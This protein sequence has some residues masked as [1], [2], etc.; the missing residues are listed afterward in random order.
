MKNIYL[1]CFSGISGNMFIGSFLDAGVPEEYLRQELQKLN[2]NN[3]Y[4]LTIDKVDKQGLHAV[5]FNVN[6]INK[7]H[8]HRC[9]DN[10]KDII[11]KSS[12]DPIVKKTALTV[13]TK[14]ASAE[15]K[16]HDADINKIH[17]HEVGAVDAIIDIVGTAICM[18]Y[19]D[20]KNIF[21]FNLH[22]GTGFVDCDHGK[23]PIPAPATAQLLQGFKIMTGTTAKELVTPTGAALIA[24][25]AQKQ[26]L[27]QTDFSFN[28]I[29]Y[30]AGTWDLDYP[31]VLR[32]YI[33]NVTETP[34]EED[35]L[36]IHVNIDDMNP[37]IFN[38]VSESLFTA[39][40]LDV[41]VTPIIMKKNRPAQMLCVLINKNICKTCC[42]IIFK[43][44]TT[45]GIRINH[46]TRVSLQ[47]KTKL[48]STVYGQVH[49]KI[50][51]YHGSVNN[52]SAEY[53]DCY[54]LAKKKNVPL[55]EIQ[56]EALRLAYYLIDN[57]K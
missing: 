55:K 47:R 52:I 11:K 49:C 15:A 48:V 39:G 33:E 24:A 21:V 28:N 46:T 44:T 6:L 25:L 8:S 29:A 27:K 16:V 10:I 42:D 17:F 35:L 34:L 43:E 40:A 2:L 3:E 7:S 54:R 13:F 51:Q 4:T 9:L 50:S 53:D 56:H 14:L 30:G 38:Y 20:V 57:N 37:Q 23:M 45:L 22:T 1:D 36:L 32:M 18:K 5:Y 19:L 31:N 26:Y 41:W 12:L